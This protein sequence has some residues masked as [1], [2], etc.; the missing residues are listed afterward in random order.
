MD[1]RKLHYLSTIDIFQDLSRKEVEQ[2]DQAVTMS[3][4]RP[5]RI[6]Y[7]PEEAGEVL[8]LLKQGTVHLYRLSPEGKKLVVAT[9]GKGAIFGEMSLIGQGMHNLFAESISDCVLCV[10]SRVD[11]ERLI[12]EKPQVAMRFMESMAARLQEAET[13]LEDLAFKSIPARL[14]ALLLRRAVED[15][16]DEILTGYTHQ[17]LAELLGTYRETIT[18]TLNEL[19][20]QGV[21]SIGRKR[22]QIL[23]RAAL[24]ELQNT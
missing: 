18:Q 16:G 7:S 12:R 22:I 9:L 11:V 13:Q 5:G 6:F 17:D 21:I 15:E 3:T 23:N 2:I 20:S 8:F 24:E 4:C 10:M 19:K 1:E 14:A